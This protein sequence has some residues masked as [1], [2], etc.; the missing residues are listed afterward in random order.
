MPCSDS[1][2]RFHHNLF[3][4]FDIKVDGLTT[5]ALWNQRQFCAALTQRDLIG[6][7]KH[8]EHLLGIVAQST[9]QYG[10]R[11]LATT[12]NSNKHVVF[13]VELKVEPRT[14]VRDYPSREQQLTR[15]VSFAF[16]VIKEHTW[17]TMQL[18][19]NNT[20]GTINNKGTIISHQR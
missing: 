20:L 13:R 9:Q 10:S 17:G 3:A 18:G 11:Q 14:T 1:T 19:D 8:F 2:T 7:E 16:V 12:V 15:A 4:N 6:I 5:Q